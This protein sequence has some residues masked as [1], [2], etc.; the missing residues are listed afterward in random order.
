MAAKTPKTLQSVLG[1]GHVMP[2]AVAPYAEWVDEFNFF[3]KVCKTT[4]KTTSWRG[5]AAPP[6]FCS[7]FYKLAAEHRQA[8]F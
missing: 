1:V 2:A 4:L 8:P 6:H 3:C 7:P 5:Q